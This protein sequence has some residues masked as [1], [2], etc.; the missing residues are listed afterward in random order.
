MKKW[1]LL[2]LIT[3]FISLVSIQ[4]FAIPTLQTY[5]EGATSGSLGPDEDTWFISDNPFNLFV[6]GAYGPNTVSL[7]DVILL[8]SIPDSET[9]TISFTT[10]DEE[11]V[12]I[13]TGA[14][15]DILTNVTGN[16]GYSTL[17][18]DYNLNNHYPLQDDVSDFLLYDLGSFDNN[19]SP[20]NDYNAENGTI[21]SSPAHGEQKEYQVSYTGFS[22]LHFDVI[23]LETTQTGPPSNPRYTSNWVI[24]PGSHDSTNDPPTDV[25]E[26]STLLL[27]GFGLIGIGLYRW[28]KLKK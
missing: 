8:I 12:L 1:I 27:M 13:T 28:R 22:R 23:G 2:I 14:D 10:S 26:P 9:G 7:T 6:V 4:A 16:D 3:I 24:N 18:D 19:E 5:I 21:T 17:P 20:L 11:P 25:P 15:V